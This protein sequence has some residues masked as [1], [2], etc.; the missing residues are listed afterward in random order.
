MA[1]GDPKGDLDPQVEKH[2]PIL[3]KPDL[4]CLVVTFYLSS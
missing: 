2:C 4:I 3:T 1:L